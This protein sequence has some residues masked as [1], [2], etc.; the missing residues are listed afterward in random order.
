[1]ASYSLTEARKRL[2]RLIDQAVAGEAVTITRRGKPIIRLAALP[3][4][5]PD[6]ADK[7]VSLESLAWL[8]RVRVGKAP[9]EDAGVTVSRLRDEEWR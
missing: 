8:D 4:G 9:A 5:R 1:M 3:A 6:G 7:R 2:S